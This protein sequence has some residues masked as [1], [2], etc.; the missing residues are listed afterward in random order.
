MEGR[1]QPAEIQD[2]GFQTEG[3]A[4]QR[5][6]GRTPVLG[7]TR[8][9]LVPDVFAAFG[10]LVGEDPAALYGEVESLVLRH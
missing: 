10:A 9:G 7:L 1:R 5:P 6:R 8:A 3:T 2:K 4:E